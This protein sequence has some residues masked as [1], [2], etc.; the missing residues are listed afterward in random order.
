MND[1][2]ESR[3]RG[4]DAG[5]R[6]FGA[7]Q[8]ADRGAAPARDVVLMLAGDVMTGRG[9]DQVLGHPGSPRL[10]E[11]HLRDARAY[12]RLAEGVHGA[13]PAPV[14][15]DYLWGDAL[16]LMQQATTDLRIVN[17][18]TAIT[19][20]DEA[21]PAKGVHYRMS[22]ANMD[23]LRAARIDACA[24]ANNHVLDWGRDGLLET[25]RALDQAGVA[26]AG[27]GADG[28]QAWAP[29]RLDLPGRG[30]LLLFSWAAMSSGVPRGWAAGPRR[31]GVAL[32]PDLSGATARVLGEDI[33]R[34]RR[35]D[36]LVV[37]S[38]HWGDNW[39]LALPQAHRDF[40]HRLIEFGT[41]DVVHGHSSHHPLPV[42]CY[43]GKLILYGCGDLVNDYE[44]IGPHGELRSDIGAVYLATLGRGGGGGGGGPA[45]VLKA[46]EIVP[47]QRERFRLRLAD[48][49]AQA[50]LE[51]VYAGGDVHLDGGLQPRGGGG[52][53][54]SR[55]QARPTAAALASTATT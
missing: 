17:L 25:L 29:A 49:A 24:L 9:I 36:D 11:T 22:P 47:F 23:C 15:A 26:F 52:W 40:A 35:P 33:L 2:R 44:G 53:C 48:A 10:S 43:R 3:D 38:I 28:D 1:P 45:G 41:A 7:R 30:Q 13:I 32:L 51:R 20:A 16:G 4:A 18:E 46:L 12:V 39:G 50:W 14:A 42:E 27:A 37:V 8:P 6:G 55:S 31:P 54:W 5:A 34:H 21:W 19:T